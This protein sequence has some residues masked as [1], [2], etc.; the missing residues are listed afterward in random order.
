MASGFKPI[1]ARARQFSYKPRYYSPEQ[2]ER[3]QRREELTGKRLDLNSNSD[4]PGDALR[5]Q[6]TARR[7]GRSERKSKGGVLFLIFGL[8]I[9]L[10]LA[11][12]LVP[13]IGEWFGGDSA[14]T[15][16]VKGANEVEE[17]NPYAPITIVPNDYQE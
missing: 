1:K 11:A 16:S 2:E 14:A 9:L 15:Q 12:N 17:F 3:E 7:K 4:K 5:R 10:M 8:A 6:I 13:L